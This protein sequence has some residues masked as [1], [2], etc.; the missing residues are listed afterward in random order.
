[1]KYYVNERVTEYILLHFWYN[2]GKNETLFFR[3]LLYF[4]HIFQQQDFS[5]GSISCRTI[6][7]PCLSS[8][9]ARTDRASLAVASLQASTRT[10]RGPHY[11]LPCVVL[12]DV[13]GLSLQRMTEIL[14]MMFSSDIV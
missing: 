9:C 10:A 8:V 11:S 5:L 4:I 1:M 7:F 2:K 12:V 14:I 3:T 6:K 13:L